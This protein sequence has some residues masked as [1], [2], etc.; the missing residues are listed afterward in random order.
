MP[1]I[2]AP[3]TNRERDLEMLHEKV[4][5]GERARAKRDAAAVALFEGGMT[6]AEIHGRLSRADRRARG[7]G[8][9]MAAVQKFIYRKRQSS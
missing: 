6:L 1:R 8:V 7:V 3:Q 2:P 4:V 9:S 5:E